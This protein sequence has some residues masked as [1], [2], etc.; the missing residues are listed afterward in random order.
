MGSFGDS[1]AQRLRSCSHTAII[2]KVPA[3]DLRDA[4]DDMPVGYSTLGIFVIRRLLI[5]HALRM[6]EED[7]QVLAPGLAVE[8]RLLADGGGLPGGLF[9]GVR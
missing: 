2:E 9:P 5:S 7:A 8:Q 1:Q 3:Q 4:E 6:E